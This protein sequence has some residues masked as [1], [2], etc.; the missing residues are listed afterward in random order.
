V[1]S[2]VPKCYPRR[3]VMAR[4]RRGNGEGGVSRRKDG[5]WM[6]RYTVQ[7]PTERKRKVIYAKS[8]AEARRKL[9]EA[10][11]ERDKG[12]TYD[13]ENLTVGEYLER[14]LEDSVRGSVKATTYQ[15]YGSLVRLHVC[16]TLGGT[17]LSAITPAHVQTLYRRKLDEG[18]APKSVKYIHTTLHRA[19]K[20]AVRWGLVPRNAASEA[21]PPR[22]VIPEMRPLSPT[23]SRTLLEAAKGN[24]L[25]ALYVLAVS[26]GMRQGE[27]LGLGWE[28]VD[29]EARTVRVRRTLTLAKGGPRLTEPKTK[30]SRRCIRL[31]SGAVDALDRHRECQEAERAAAG[32]VWNAWA[33][34]FCTKRGTPIRRD[35]L[36]D[37][38]W[39]P[40]LARAGL[41]DIRFH[42]LRHTCATLLLTKGVHPKIVSEMLG[43]SSIAITLDTYS[44]VIPGLGEVAASAMEEA[45]GDGPCVDGVGRDDAQ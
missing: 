7:T 26:T 13:S 41:P 33:L 15:S 9:T 11:A 22:V 1:V 21:D 5:S 31:T 17:K 30:G 44:H 39:K 25:E 35:N 6:A 40:L 43:H 45:L 18:L 34:V 28:G 19:L 16:P 4:Q 42:D 27:L 29:L 36:H 14:W 2:P 20:Q 8:Q 24:R 12:L 38:H 23:Q 32:G 37:K 3:N 10:I